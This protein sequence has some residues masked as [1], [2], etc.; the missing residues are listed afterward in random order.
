[1][2]FWNALAIDAR[3]S[4]AQPRQLTCQVCAAPNHADADFCRT[5]RAPLVLAYEAQW[6]RT[7]PRFLAVTGTPGCGKTVYLGMLT[8]RLSRHG[9]PLQVLMRGAYSVSLQQ[10]A[11]A[12]LARRRFPDPTPRDPEGW[13]WMHCDV[14]GVPRKRGR[15]IVMP[16]ISGGA[17]RQEIESP[18]SLP[19]VRAFLSRCSAAMLLVDAEAVEQGDA[20]QDY[21]AVQSLIYLV[22]M[23]RRRNMAWARCPVAVVFTKADASEA[24]RDEPEEFARERTPGLWHQCRERLRR[25]R[26][27]ACSVV[28]AC[29]AIEIL[30]E[31]VPIP[32]RIEPHGVVEPFRWLVSEMGN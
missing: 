9:G 3:R 21:W 1:M 29:A 26:F 11:M 18:H 32:L 22:E 14:L 6:R 2:S 27:F 19:I 8:D 10:E 28:G 17:I 13:N 31:T 7:V 12:A 4:A 25:R 20:D 23:Q 5:C 30:G 15:E 24:C 16:D